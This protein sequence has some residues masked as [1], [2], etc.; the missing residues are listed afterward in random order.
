MYEKN[1]TRSAYSIHQIDEEKLKA[2]PTIE[3][4][5]AKLDKFVATNLPDID[6][7]DIVLFGSNVAFDKSFL[8]EAYDRT[9]KKFPFDYHILDLPSIYFLWYA[10]SHGKIPHKLTLNAMCKQKGVTNECPHSAMYDIAATVGILR[11]IMGKLNESEEGGCD[12][13]G[14]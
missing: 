7:K 14:I 9:G 10:T 3:K 1:K 12:K 13:E 5:L 11:N 6:P 8:E 2:A 4:T